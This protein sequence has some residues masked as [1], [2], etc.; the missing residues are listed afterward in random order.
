M[1]EEN[2]KVLGVI[3]IFAVINYVY[4]MADKKQR[5]SITS[6]VPFI[7]YSVP[8]WKIQIPCNGGG[9]GGAGSSG[10]SHLHCF[11][12]VFQNDENTVNI[13]VSY[14]LIHYILVGIIIQISLKN[15]IHRQ[16]ARR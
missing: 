3:I 4:C 16:D 14:N 15:S 11:W 13:S 1:F 10:E 6:E 7:Q 2:Y 12:T 8:E 9:G 5:I